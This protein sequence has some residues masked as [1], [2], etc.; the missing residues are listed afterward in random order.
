MLPVCLSQVSAEVSRRL[1]SISVDGSSP[2]SVPV[3]G[4]QLDVDNRLYLGGL[5]DTHST[6]RINVRHLCY[7]SN[8]QDL[9]MSI[10]SNT[11][12]DALMLLVRPHL[13]NQGLTPELNVTV[14]TRRCICIMDLTCSTCLSLR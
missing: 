2:D 13:L 10:V 4:N 5:P 3:K 8:T 6:R 9:N 11:S 12:P 7:L 14:S 1:V